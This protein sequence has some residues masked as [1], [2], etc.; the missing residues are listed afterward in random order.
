M[1]QPGNAAAKAAGRAL[2]VALV[3]A[4]KTVPPASKVFN[5][6]PPFGR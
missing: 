5:P 3:A 2:D 1:F 6:M 4:L